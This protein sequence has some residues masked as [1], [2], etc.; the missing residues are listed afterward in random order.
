MFFSSLSSVSYEVSCAS[1]LLTFNGFKGFDFGFRVNVVALI[2]EV[3]REG[4]A[5]Y[6]EFCS[7]IM[8]RFLNF[9]ALFVN[10]QLL[11]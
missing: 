1:L 6:S 11:F 3:S 8:L 9:L 5:S 2:I 10:I 4:A 7:W